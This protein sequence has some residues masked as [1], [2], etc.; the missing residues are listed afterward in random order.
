M[1]VKYLVTTI[2]P[3]VLAAISP[4][5]SLFD[6]AG[7]RSLLARVDAETAR[8]KKVT[9]LLAGL[10]P[11]EGSSAL[12][13]ELEREQE[14]IAFRLAIF[15]RRISRHQRNPNCDLTLSESLFLWFPSATDLGA[16]LRTL[17]YLF[18]IVGLTVILLLISSTARVIAA[19]AKLDLV[20]IYADLAIISIYL[21]MVFRG[22]ALL[23]R[24]WAHPHRPSLIAALHP[25]V[26]WQ[27]FAAQVSL[28]AC[29]FSAIESLEDF[30]LDFVKSGK[31]L[32]MSNEQDVIYR[33]LLSLWAL[34][35][36]LIWAKAEC[37]RRDGKNRVQRR[38]YWRTITPWPVAAV[39]VAA[40]VLAIL[41]GLDWAELCLGIFILGAVPLRL[42][43]LQAR[44]RGTTATGPTAPVKART[45]SG[46]G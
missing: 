12:R 22:W 32:Q 6:F 34:S 9:R 4:L 45:Q 37:R 41:E 13:K 15:N 39:G 24:K 46:A 17:A 16:K 1:F 31:Q 7:K 14:S 30:V 29:V 18:P 27:M 11:G 42:L 19:L 20:H 26:N 3:A 10:E 28:W 8:G 5:I 25:P 23:A 44:R 43:Q 36:C 21:A 2:I 38:N 35:A 40:L 33:F